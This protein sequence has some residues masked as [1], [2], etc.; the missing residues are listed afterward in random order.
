MVCGS[1]GTFL[2]PVSE[3]VSN[4]DKYD[5]KQTC[6]MC[7]NDK[8]IKEIDVPYIFKYLVTQLASCNIKIKMSLNEI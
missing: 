8:N 5:S 6:R 3:L 7:K 4:R 1:C 2:G